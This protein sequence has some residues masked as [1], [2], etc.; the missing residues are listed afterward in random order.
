MALTMKKLCLLVLAL[1]LGGA[2]GVWFWCFRDTPENK[3]RQVM[4]TLAECV[5]KQPGEGAAS[6][7][8]KIRQG[9]D[10]FLEPCRIE[11]DGTMFH[12]EELS[13]AVIQSHL[14]RF[15][16]IFTSVRA[17]VEHTEVRLTGEY[18]ARM[19]FTGTLHGTFQTG[20]T[21]SEVRN[22]VAEFRIC[23][24]NLWRI[25]RLHVQNVLER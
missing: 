21:I 8:L 4:L 5:T 13:Q 16:K 20:K 25:E 23:E 7:L 14:A 11:I 1:L 6:G 2:A 10:L 19:E 9:T 24:D 15:R 3:I 12:G 22:L 17:G 18:T